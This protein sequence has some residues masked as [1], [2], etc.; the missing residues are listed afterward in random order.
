MSGPLSWKDYLFLDWFYRRKLSAFTDPAQRVGWISGESQKARFDAFY[1]IGA[2]EGKRVLDVGSGLGDFYGY[3]QSK[4]WNGS[5]T[6]FDRLGEMVEESRRR[7]P[8]VRFEKRN[9]AEQVTDERW[10]YVFMS[11]LF[12]HR[13]R[14]NWGWISQVVSPAQRLSQCGTAFNLLSDTN[15]D[16]DEDFFYA[17]REE[18]GRFAEALAP[19]RWRMVSCALPHDLTIFLYP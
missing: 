12:N 11:G 4:G 16:Q 10:D 17:S 2:L 15:P 19:G 5:Y 18:L 1:Q 13:V 14:D 6:G 9:I 3:L 7:Y 8:G